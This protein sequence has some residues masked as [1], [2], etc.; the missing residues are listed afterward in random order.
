MVCVTVAGTVIV[1]SQL[2]P[3]I[4]VADGPV[5]S[6]TLSSFSGTSYALSNTQKSEIRALVNKSPEANTVTCTG[7]RFAGTSKA[8]AIAIKKRAQTACSYAKGLDSSLKTTVVTRTTK[9]KSNGG[10][11]QLSLRVEEIVA[12]PKP[13]EDLSTAAKI[14]ADSD[15]SS[16]SIC[17]TSDVTPNG[18]TSNGS[19]R[20]S[21]GFPRPANAYIGKVKARILY[22]PISFTDYKYVQADLDKTKSVTDDVT[23]FYKATSYGNVELTYEF[24]PEDKWV[25][26][27][28]SAASYNLPNNQPQQNNQQVVVDALALVDASVDFNLYDGVVVSSTYFR[29]PGGGQG[30][31]GEEFKVKTGVA[32]G[33]SLEFGTAVAS[34]TTLAH[35]LGHSLFGLEDLYVFLNANRPSVPD[36]T[37]AGRWDMMS[38]SNREFFGWN[39]LLNGWLG[40]TQM[41][42]ITNQSISYHYLERIDMASEKPKLTLINLAEGVTLG[43]ETRYSGYGNGVL[44]YKV[45]TRIS[46]G[47][48]PIIAQKSLLS[49]GRSLEIDGWR[50]TPVDEDDN[51]LLV[52][53]SKLGS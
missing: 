46:H 38:T 4:T 16:A 18:F 9:L 39:K 37:P 51:G 47:D 42:C 2:A 45:D 32:K 26:M 20:S 11:V 13:K 27:G 8:M 7:L 15:L 19:P 28:R 12:T 5:T 40:D 22:V 30:F 35:E 33:V 3:V 1:A 52:E 34:F 6:K 31:F 14:T 49:T 10:K 24:L 36:P 43:I 44:V 50:I 21:N 17:K 29:S 41:R 25:Q 48:G 53:V 23:A